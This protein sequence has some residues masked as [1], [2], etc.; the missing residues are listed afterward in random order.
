MIWPA[1]RDLRFWL[2]ASALILA[3]ATRVMPGIRLKHDAYDVL[4][5]V[6]VTGSMN[7]PDA[8]AAGEPAS[9][10]EAVKDRLRGLAAKLPCQ[11]R[12]GFGIFSERRAFILFTPVEVCS[13]F[14]GVDAAITALDWRMAWEGDSYVANGIYD[15]IRYAGDLDANLLFFTDG[16]EA[17]PLPFSGTPKFEGK[18]GDVKGLIV[19][20]GGI[21]PTPIP[22]FDDEGR[23]IGV[24]GPEDV[25][26]ENRSGPPPPDAASRPGYHPKWAPYGSATG[27]G[28]QHLSSVKEE[29]LRLIASLTG[30]AYTTL[31]GTNALL[32]AFEAAAVPHEVVVETDIRAYPAGLALLLLVV[33]YGLLPLRDRLATGVSAPLSGRRRSRWSTSAKE[34]YA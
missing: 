24:L 13:N 20:V 17:P 27:T 29:H 25:M 12:L 33:V 3:I 34:E 4:A 26:Q 21:A 8:T 6:D 15:A 11:S 7:T 16:H 23:E 10:L 30:L 19:G 9:R 22:K 28:T 14:A 31:D 18:T 32:R 5:I 2:L 1:L